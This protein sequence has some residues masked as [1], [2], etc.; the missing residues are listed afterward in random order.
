MKH[1]DRG[2]IVA[3]MHLYGF[4]V[5][6]LR[7]DLFDKI[8]V[9]EGLHVQHGAVGVTPPWT[10]IEQYKRDLDVFHR[11]LRS[12]RHSISNVIV[13]AQ[14]DVAK[15]ISYGQ[16]RLIHADGESWQGEGWYEDEW[17][18]TAQG[19]RIRKRQARVSWAAGDMR[20]RSPPAAPSTLHN[21][22]LAQ[23]ILR[24]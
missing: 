13:D 4:A 23:T 20:G 3:N 1:E 21:I 19:W 5:D 9:Q 2:E 10:D 16:Y 7:W 18:R 8:F 6:S 22:D 12:S 11:K 14:G 17:T 15:S 24:S